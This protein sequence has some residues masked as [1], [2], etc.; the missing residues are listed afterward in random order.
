MTDL[1]S[2][3]LFALTISAIIGAG[4]GVGSTF[5][6]QFYFDKPKI[7]SRIMGVVTAEMHNPILSKDWAAFFVYVYLSNQHQN[8]IYILDYE[9]EVDL[10]QGYEKISR[11]YGDIEKLM[12]A[13]TMATI[14]NKGK[15]TANTLEMSRI[16]SHLISKNNRP[17]KYGDYVNGAVLFVG[18]YRLHGNNRIRAIKFSC[19]DVLGKRHTIEVK[20]SEFVRSEVLFELLGGTIAIP[21]PPTPTHDYP[22]VTSA[23]SVSSPTTVATSV[24]RPTERDKPIGEITKTVKLRTIPKPDPK[25]AAVFQGDKI[26]YIRGEEKGRGEYSYVC[27]K[28]DAV[29][30]DHVQSDKTVRGIVFFCPNC[31]TYNLS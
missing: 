26:P 11:A 13:G 17:V 20:E 3:Q 31:L 10:G 9:A 28:C 25:R 18:D 5:L 21:D 30:V 24:A 1:F 4:V 14:G 23:G 15:G 8:A 27:G 12:P 29:L 16:M 22:L 6:V 19:I 2:S 7:V